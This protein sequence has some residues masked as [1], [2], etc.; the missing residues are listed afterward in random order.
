MN[1]PLMPRR[2]KTRPLGVGALL[3][4]ILVLLVNLAFLGAAAWVVATVVKAVFGL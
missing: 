1:S 3:L 2:R 4:G